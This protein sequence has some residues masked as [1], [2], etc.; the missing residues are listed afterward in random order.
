MIERVTTETEI[1]NPQ[2]SM[3][4]SKSERTSDH[5]VFPSKVDPWL[6]FVLVLP[7]LVGGAAGVTLLVQGGDDGTHASMLFAIS[8]GL[9]IL[10]GILVLPC[11]YTFLDDALSVRCGLICYQIPYAEIRNIEPSRSWASAPALSLDRIEIRSDQR[12]VLVSPQDREGFLQEI[13]RRCDVGQ[14]HPL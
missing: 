3:A 6:A 7:S 14:P 9:L 2:G 4:E 13:R 11:R 1:K 5:T 8:A 12:T 10:H